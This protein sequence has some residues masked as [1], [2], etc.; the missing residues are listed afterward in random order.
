MSR[1]I[2]QREL[3]FA[4]L[5]I[6]VE[7]VGEDIFI[8]I[9]GGDKPHLG[10]VVLAIPRKSLADEKISSCTS[11]VLNVTGHKDEFICRAVAESFCKKFRAV[12]VCTGGFHVDNI[13]ATQ[14]QEVV[15]ACKF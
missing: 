7:R 11:S 14:I 15:D 10:S 8:L 5:T 13:T 3:S 6:E 12:T 1:E 4:T 2:I 9:R